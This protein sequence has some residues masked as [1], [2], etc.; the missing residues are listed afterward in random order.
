[1]INSVPP[2]HCLTNCEC[3][4]TQNKHQ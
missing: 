3:T 1:M 2:D 4:N